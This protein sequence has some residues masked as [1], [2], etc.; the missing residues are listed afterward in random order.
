MKQCRRQ[1]DR[2]TH[3]GIVV[4]CKETC[5]S[6]AAGFKTF[7]TIWNLLPGLYYS[8][9]FGFFFVFLILIPIGRLGANQLFPP[10]IYS[11]S[12]ASSKPACLWFHRK[13]C[14]IMAGIVCGLL[15]TMLPMPLLMLMV[16]LVMFTTA[17]C[18]LPLTTH[19]LVRS[20]G[21]FTHSFIVGHVVVARLSF[22]TYVIIPT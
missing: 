9:L 7:T 1:L 8:R 5:C 4:I 22:F 6:Y 14:F 3:C 18:C 19:S 20:F 17:V 21:L 13:F 11:V 15:L 2:A 16:V 12:E 10:A